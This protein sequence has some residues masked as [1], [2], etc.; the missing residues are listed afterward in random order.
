M[1]QYFGT[2]MYKINAEFFEKSLPQIFEKYGLDQEL[3]VDWSASRPRIAFGH[4]DDEGTSSN[5]HF[6]VFQRVA[7]R[8]KGDLN[9]LFYEEFQTSFNLDFTLQQEVFFANMKD[10]NVYKADLDNTHKVVERDLPLFDGLDFDEDQY[11]VFWGFVEQ[12]A[13]AWQTYWNDYVLSKGIPMPYWNLETL[14][15]FELHP[16]ALSGVLSL[17]YHSV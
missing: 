13:L 8:K 2:H 17:F 10:V 14:T 16:G 11:A 12:K 7:I 1:G 4:E 3:E 6:R 15:Y 5:L 9:Y